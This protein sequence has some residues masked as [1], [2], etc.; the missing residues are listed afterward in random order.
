MHKNTE[1]MNGRRHADGR[2]LLHTLLTATGRWNGRTDRHTA[3]RERWSAVQRTRWEMMD[4]D[5]VTGAVDNNH[6]LTGGLHI[7]FIHSMPVARST[8]HNTND[9]IKLSCLFKVDDNRHYHSNVRHRR[10]FLRRADASPMPPHFVVST[11]AGRY[12]KNGDDGIAGWLHKAR[13]MVWLCFCC[14]VL[15]D[16]SC[17]R[18]SFCMW[19]HGCSMLMYDPRRRRFIIRPCPR[20]PVR[21]TDNPA[22]SHSI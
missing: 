17:R 5:K 13:A 1:K 3:C 11:A 19:R 4:V 9:V 7:P 10:F 14:V 18:P 2:L 12:D 20:L 15:S 21:Q 22:A 16:S 8:Q 6:A